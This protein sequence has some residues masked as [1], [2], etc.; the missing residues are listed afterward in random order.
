MMLDDTP[1]R[2]PNVRICTPGGRQAPGGADHATFYAQSSEFAIS[3]CWD[4]HLSSI[5]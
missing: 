1:P 3:V 2:H 4:D 5:G